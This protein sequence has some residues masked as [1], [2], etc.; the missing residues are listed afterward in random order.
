MERTVAE[1][2]SLASCRCARR[3]FRAHLHTLVIISITY[4]ILLYTIM[5][6]N[7]S[8]YQPPALPP[9]SPWL[10]ICLCYHTNAPTSAP[11]AP[12]APPAPAPAPAPPP[13]PPPPPPTANRHRQP[14]PPRPMPTPLP[15]AKRAGLQYQKA[16]YNSRV[17]PQCSLGAM[18]GFPF[19]ALASS[20]FQVNQLC[21][22]G[23]SGVVLQGMNLTCGVKLFLSNTY[24]TP[25]VSE[26]TLNASSLG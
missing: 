1:A 9:V 16:L 11:P 24:V 21:F 8:H 17:N 18:L 3:T 23:S 10:E 26:G 13:P 15:T 2:T 5:L 25:E 7:Q 4:F 19:K 12:P 20:H 22:Q 14:P 6:L